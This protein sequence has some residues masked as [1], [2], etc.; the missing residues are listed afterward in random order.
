MSPESILSIVADVIGFIVDVVDT[1][2]DENAAESQFTTSVVS[3]L[4]AQYPEKNILIYHGMYTL[5]PLSR[6]E[7]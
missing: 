5:A 1:L 6:N 2:E 7:Y 4:A 3:Q